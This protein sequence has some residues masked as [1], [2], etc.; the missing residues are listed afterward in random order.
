LLANSSFIVSVTIEKCEVARSSTAVHPG[1]PADQR[2]ANPSDIQRQV[3]GGLSEVNPEASA[4][5]SEPDRG[6]P[7]GS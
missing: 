7:I 1:A 2:M 5:P 4:G 6:G 3:L